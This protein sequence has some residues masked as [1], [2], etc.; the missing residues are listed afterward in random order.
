[1]GF[2][3]DPLAILTGVLVGLM[4]LDLRPSRVQ[5]ALLIL[6]TFIGIAVGANFQ[7]NVERG[8][9]VAFLANRTKIVHF[10]DDK[11]AKLRLELTRFAATML[12]LGIVRFGLPV[13]ASGFKRHPWWGI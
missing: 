5:T 6:A 4:L 2:L 8:K 13:T 3:A 9:Y 11:P 12:W 10:L 1:M 7:I